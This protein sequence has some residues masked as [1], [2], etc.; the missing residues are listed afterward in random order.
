MNAIAWS[1]LGVA[2]L[3]LPG[4]DPVAARADALAAR[5]RLAEMPRDSPTRWAP[6]PEVLTAVASLVLTVAVLVLAGPVLAAAAGVVCATTG[7][8]ALRARRSRAQRRRAAELLAAV[9]LASAELDA[10][11]S[12]SAA[13]FAAAEVAPGHAPA[14]RAAAEACR[15]GHDPPWDERELRP[16][17]AAWNVAV[18]T[19]APLAAVLTRVADDFAARQTHQRAVTAAV[20]GARSSAG[21]LAGLP[22]LGLALGAAMQAH[23]LDVLFGTPEGRLLC[24]VGVGLDAAGV[25]WT[26]RLTARAERA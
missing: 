24:L 8:T 23:P 15:L 26:Q 17:A 5:G 9:R 19:G 20:A 12:P 11:S 4:V 21:L 22:V 18:A 10:G 25:I 13:L 14:L 16:V 1:A 3:L 6:R 2:V 7:R